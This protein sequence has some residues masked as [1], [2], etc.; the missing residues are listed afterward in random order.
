MKI[1][2]RRINRAVDV[3]WYIDWAYNQILINKET[4]IKFSEDRIDTNMQQVWNTHPDGRG[5]WKLLLC[6]A[7]SDRLRAQQQQ[8]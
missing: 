4:W 1:L 5:L 8:A 3:T 2:Y 7:E 6:I